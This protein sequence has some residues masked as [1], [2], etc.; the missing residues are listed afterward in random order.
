MYRHM[1]MRMNSNDLSYLGLSL[2]VTSQ[3][4]YKRNNSWQDLWFL[5]HLRMA[6]FIL[7]FFDRSIFYLVSKFWS[8]FGFFQ[9]R[10]GHFK[11]F[12]TAVFLKAI[13]SQQIGTKV[14]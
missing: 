10:L 12:E 14:V 11:I 8:A 4:I 3:T 13:V 9:N 6:T 5:K 1:Q 2:H 7:L